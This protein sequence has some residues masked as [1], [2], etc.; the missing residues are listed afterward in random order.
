MPIE[1]LLRLGTVRR[2]VRWGEDPVMHRPAEA[3][4]DFDGELQRLIADMFATN[5]AAGG[6]GLAACQIGVG[7]AVF[8]YDCT[9]HTGARRTGVVCNPRVVVAEGPGRELV[10]LGEGCLSLPGAWI[11]T[12]R[13]RWATCAGRDQYGDAIE[14]SAGGTL[15]RCLQHESDHLA[16]MVFGDRLSGRVR[17][18][19]LAAH[20][21]VAQRYPSDWPV[22]PMVAPAR[23]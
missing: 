13:P 9:D 12:A 10:E 22:G 20:Q 19:L 15:G 18:Q 6:A 2:I 14:V 5:T 3:V 16:G 1:E 11:A 21:A 8:V 7:L 4:T 23:D 17:R